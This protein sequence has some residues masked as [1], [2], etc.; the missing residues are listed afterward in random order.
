MTPRLAR[1]TAKEL[2]RILVNH[3]FVCKRVKGSHHHFVNSTSGIG[4]TV[5][6]HA[7][8]IIG[9]G[10]LKAILKQAKIPFEALLKK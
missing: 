7:G 9:P 2:I 6:V 3:G 5:P 8:K 4:I 1:I 10:L